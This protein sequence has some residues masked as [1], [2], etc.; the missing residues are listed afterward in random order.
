MYRFVSD[1]ESDILIFKDD[2]E[3]LRL[4]KKNIFSTKYEIFQEK[5]LILTYRYYDF[6]GFERIKILDNKFSNKFIITNNGCKTELLSNGDLFRIKFNFFSKLRK[7]IAKI[8]LNEGEI[9]SIV[10]ENSFSLKI[11]FLQGYEEY[12]VFCL[13]LFLIKYNFNDWM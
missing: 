7:K 10:N 1:S 5:S 3:V 4:R 9:G 6:L 8:M 13:I 11:Y 2:N 12:E